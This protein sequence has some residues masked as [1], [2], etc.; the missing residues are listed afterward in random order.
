MY[1][2]EAIY[3]NMDTNKAR[4]H[5]VYVDTNV[6]DNMTEKDAFCMAMTLAYDEKHDN[7]LLS[8]LEFISA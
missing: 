8:S 2:F 5:A 1:T 4:S 6:T 7:E 3:I